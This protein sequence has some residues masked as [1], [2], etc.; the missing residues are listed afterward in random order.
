MNQHR[1]WQ[2]QL[3]EEEINPFLDDNVGNPWGD[4]NDVPVIHQEVTGKIFQFIR[5]MKKDR[6]HRSRS[7]VIYGFAGSGKSHLLARIRKHTK[8]S[9]YFTFVQPMVSEVD[10]WQYLQRQIIGSL[11]KPYPLNPQYRQ[12]H[13]LI[14]CGIRNLMKDVLIPPESNFFE[15]L[16]ENPINLIYYLKNYDNLEKQV[17]AIASDKIQNASHS[18][19]DHLR[20]LLRFLHSSAKE[21]ASR[22][23]KCLGVDEEECSVLGISKRFSVDR[24]DD[25]FARD[26]LMDL[27]LLSI[28]DRPIVLC[29][30]QLDNYTRKNNT[31]KLQI[32]GEIVETI[33]TFFPNILCVSAILNATYEE[34]KKIISDPANHDRVLNHLFALQ[35]ITEE[36]MI[37]DLICSRLKSLH[38]KF[39]ITQSVFPFPDNVSKRVKDDLFQQ[40]SELYPRHI[41]RYCANEYNRALERD[42]PSPVPLEEFLFQKYTGMK[43]FFT[44]ENTQVFDEQMEEEQVR[45]LLQCVID[46][47]SQS[48]IREI[49]DCRDRRDKPWDF[50]FTTQ[51]RKNY[52]VEIFEGGSNIWY[53]RKLKGVLD[54]W[55][56][57]EIESVYWIR[58]GN[59]KIQLGRLGQERLA[60]FKQLGGYL[61]TEWPEKEWN[62]I[63]SLIWVLNESVGGNLLHYT[64]KGDRIVEPAEV[65]QWIAASNILHELPLVRSI[66]HQEGEGGNGPDIPLIEYKLEEVAQELTNIVKRNRI[67]G[68]DTA[69]KELTSLAKFQNLDRDECLRSIELAPKIGCTTQ[70]VQILYWVGDVS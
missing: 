46:H 34:Y 21:T 51:Q 39:G 56:K 45:R 8:D 60:E 32:Y 22:W 66:L 23:M 35:P 13:Y 70:S 68:F 3:K 49:R 20:V 28:Y 65:E 63:R 62:A 29:F 30:D 43:E 19:Q 36:A 44:K 59:N 11:M 18:I 58:R 61:F 69:Y 40:E 9:A 24:I 57:P 4:V 38:E 67:M 50:E 25:T 12:L 64:E 37:H 52:A 16:D 33:V 31:Q 1:E 5:Q 55:E 7:V 53:A 42:I 17:L 27:S 48:P 47:H 41:I 26:F 54:A 6:E 14:C 2:Q 15:K 10:Y